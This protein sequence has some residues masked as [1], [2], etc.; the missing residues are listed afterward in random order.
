MTRCRA[1]LL[2]CAGGGIVVDAKAFVDAWSDSLDRGV[3]AVFIGAGLSRR[4]GYPD[5][6]QLLRDLAQELGLDIDEE[7][8]LAA[9][10][11]YS[12]NKSA[13]NRSKLSRLIARQFPP[14]PDA[15]LPFHVLA[16]LP[17][18]HVW[19]TNYDRL[20]ELAWPAENK[21]LD[22]KYQNNHLSID[23][24]WAHSVLYKMHGSVD[25][26][27]GV[28][29]AKDDYEL[30][31]R[32]RPGFLQVLTGDLVTKQFLFL[33][34]SFT[35]PNIAHLFASIREAFRE[36]GPQHY[37]IVRRPKLAGGTG[38]RKR[39]R[40][41]CIRHDLWVNDLQRYGI[42]CVE[43]E[44]YEDI[45]DI[46]HRVENRLASKSVFVSGSFPDTPSSSTRLAVEAVA[47][48]VGR[49]VAESQKRLVSGY[50]LVV[51]SAAI[52]GALGVIM[53]QSAPNLERSLLLRP[54]PREVPPGTD[55]DDFKTRYRESL[56]RQAG[57]CIFISGL[58]ETTASGVETAPGVLEEYRLARDLGRTVLP[59]GATGGA[60]RLIWQEIDR[61]G[62]LPPGLTRPDFDHLNDPS[63][64]PFELSHIVA[65]ALAAP[66]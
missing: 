61:S 38:S 66:V 65:K 57:T 6:R 33:G 51:G 22:V 29:I 49:I 59:I 41:D 4:A 30:Y 46:L 26:A 5:W 48:D 35:D 43:V 52:S 14:R 63:L 13:G 25:D 39:Y 7:S 15:P 24:P 10:A 50:G 62:D 44:E 54:F 2:Q 3:A 31:R 53:Q 9:V 34:F 36:N 18:R 23:D 45:D 11:Q 55:A 20:A 16:R 64:S 17:I 27:A 28:V 47:R 1:G 56:V 37:A 60:A 19:T 42:D 8:D 21:V 40:I 32:E 58:R 12:V